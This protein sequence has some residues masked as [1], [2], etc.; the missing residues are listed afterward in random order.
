MGDLVQFLFNGQDRCRLVEINGEPWFVAVD[1]CKIL[2]LD[3][4]RQAV[5]RLWDHQVRITP[6]ITSDGSRD[7]NVV[8]EGGLYRLIFTSRK[9]EAEAFAKWV[10]DEV[11]PTI[12]KTGRYGIAPQ[13]VP[14]PEAFKAELRTMLKDTADDICYGVSQIMHPLVTVENQNAEILRFGFKLQREIL[15]QT[16]PPKLPLNSRA[17]PCDGRQRKLR[18]RMNK[19]GLP[20]ELRARIGDLFPETFSRRK[21]IVIASSPASPQ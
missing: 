16:V 21:P 20:S 13:S 2:D 1:V 11:L 7:A 12:R 6:V 8:N 14:I 9:P 17:K 15:E 5:S 19:R 4:P 18:E 3:N 10:C